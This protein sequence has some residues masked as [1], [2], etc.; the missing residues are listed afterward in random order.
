MVRAAV[1]KYWLARLREKADSLSFLKYLRTS[2]MGLTR[3]HPIFLTCGS[4]PWETEKAVTQGRLLS[5]R[6]RVDSLS[7]HWVPWNRVVLVY[8]NKYNCPHSFLGPL[9]NV[10]VLMLYRQE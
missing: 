5:G 9:N 3:C 10:N 7:G 1:L 8:L 4:S 2:F 6:Y